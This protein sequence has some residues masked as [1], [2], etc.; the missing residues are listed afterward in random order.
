MRKTISS[1]LLAAFLLMLCGF[2]LQSEAGAAPDLWT[3]QVTLTQDT[4]DKQKSQT[5]DCSWYTRNDTL[6]SFNITSAEQLASVAK[7]VNN[8]YQK[9]SES[10]TGYD[11]VF[12]D[13]ADKVLLIPDDL[14]LSGHDW[15][16]IGTEAH[17]FRGNLLGVADGDTGT[18][19]TIS[20]LRVTSDSAAAGLYGLLGCVDS[21]K[22]QE[23]GISCLTVSGEITI[24]SGS[25]IA[26]AFA[27]KI[28]GVETPLSNLTADVTITADTTGDVVIGGIAGDVSN[29]SLLCCTNQGAVSVLNAAKADVGG[30][31]GIARNAVITVNASDG[32]TENRGVL[33]V[34]AGTANVGGIIGSL[35]GE[36]GNTLA[37]SSK[38]RSSGSGAEYQVDNNAAFLVS[39]GDLTVEA[40]VSANVGGIIGRSDIA[41]NL[42]HA[43]FIRN[44]TV[45]GSGNACVGGILGG[46]Y[47]D[48]TAVLDHGSFTTGIVLK[49]SKNREM[50]RETGIAAKISVT[51]D[52]TS[53][54][55]GICGYAERLTMAAPFAGCESG[56]KTGT[57]SI[58]VKSEAG[59][60]GG[61]AGCVKSGT[62]AVTAEEE[63]QV[64][65][66]AVSAENAAAVGAVLGDAV[67]TQ[68]FHAAGRSGDKAQDITVSA[69][70]CGNVG[71]FIG[72]LQTENQVFLTADHIS[73]STEDSSAAIGGAVGTVTKCGDITLTVSQVTV[74]AADAEHCAIGG[75][76]GVNHLSG[77]LTVTDGAADTQAQ[78]TLRFDGSESAVGGMIGENHQAYSDVSLRLADCK[79]NMTV[80]GSKCDVGGVIGESFAVLDGGWSRETPDQRISL[81]D[82]SVT[83]TLTESNIGGAAGLLHGSMKGV[84][85]QRL[86]IAQKGTGSQVGGLAGR[87][88]QSIC[89]AALFSAEI[90][91]DGADNTAGGA[92]GVYLADVT[93]ANVTILDSKIINRAAGSIIGGFA[94]ENRGLIRNLSSA[95]G[96]DIRLM[97]ADR[98]VAGGL[99]GSNSGEIDAAA[100]AARI[101]MPNANNSALSG[102]RIGG[103]VGE[104]TAAGS[105]R[106][107]LRDTAIALDGN[108]TAEQS[109]ALGGLIGRNAGLVENS[110]AACELSTGNLGNVYTG[111]LIGEMKGGSVRNCYTGDFRLTA[112]ADQA[113]L[114]GFLGWYQDGT[115]ENCYSAMEVVGAELDRGGAF[116]AC[117][118]S[119]DRELSEFSDC[120]FIQ[121]KNTVNSGLKAAATGSYLEF[122]EYPEALRAMVPE[123]L[124][125][126][127]EGTV[128]FRRYVDGKWDFENVWRFDSMVGEIGYA[129]PLLRM[130]LPAGSV[131]GRMDLSWYTDHVKQVQAQ[132]ED[133]FHL[134]SET[135]LT[136]F[137][138]LVNGYVMGLNAVDFAGQTVYLDCAVS[139]QASDWNAI[140]DRSDFAFAGSFDGQEKQISGL[141]DAADHAAGLFG[142]T[143]A[144]A[145]LRNVRLQAL[146]VESKYGAAAAA[147]AYHGGK[148]QNVTVTLENHA[149]IRGGTY[150]GG[151]AG[152]STGSIAQVSV[153][154]QNVVIT[155]A[156]AGGIAGESSKDI[157]DAAV[158]LTDGVIGSAAT[159]YAGG[160]AGKSGAALTGSLS[161]SATVQGKKAGGIV[162]EGV[163]LTATTAEVTGR[164]I[165][166]DYAGG[167]AGILSG[168]VEAEHLTV[169]AE[170]G[171]TGE[172]FSGGIAGKVSAAI[173]AEMIRV[174]AASVSGACSGGIAGQGM[175]LTVTT[176]EV[177]GK[178]IGTDY[179]GGIAGKIGS[180]TDTALICSGTISG[181]GRVGGMAGCVTGSLLRSSLDGRKSARVCGGAFVGGA[182]GEY[183]GTELDGSIRLSEISV[184]DVEIRTDN[185]DTAACAGGLFGALDKAFL[186]ESTLE[187]VTVE[188]KGNQADTMIGGIAGQVTDSIL[189]G[190]SAENGT[191][192]ARCTG[193]VYIGGA[194]GQLTVSSNADRTWKTEPT[195]ILGAYQGLDRV[196]LSAV[197]VSTDSGV[198]NE[199]K[200][201]YLTGKEAYAGGLVGCL[202]G[203][204]VYHCTVS[205][206]VLA[207]AGYQNLYVGGAAGRA[208]DA[209][210]V[211]NTV[212]C[213][214][215]A[216]NALR[217]Y[218]GGFV[219]ELASSTARYDRT[220]NELTLALHVGSSKAPILYAGGFA[221]NILGT[222]ENQLRDN[223]AV[224]KLSAENDHLNGIIYAGGFAGLAGYDQKAVSLIACTAEAELSVRSEDGGVPVGADTY[225]GGL[226][227]QL[228][229]GTIESS[230]ARSN[231]SANVCAR[232]RSGGFAGSISENAAAVN[233]FVVGD[234]VK[235]HGDSSFCG[236]FVGECRGKISAV[237]ADVADVQGDGDYVGPI[238]GL[239]HDISNMEYA[240]S[241]GLTDG[242]QPEGF[243]FT[244]ENSK[245]A[246]LEGVNGNRPM[247]T[248]FVSWDSQPELDYL[249][250][251]GANA[252]TVADASELGTVSALLN[253]SSIYALFSDGRRAA[254]AYLVRLTAD[255]KLT[256]E[257]VWKLWVPANAVLDGEQ[258]TINGIQV[259]LPD[260]AFCGFVME[261]AGD[262]RNLTIA[263]AE[264]T[265]GEYAGAA[266]G[267]NTGTLEQVIVRSSAISVADCV[268]VVVGVNEGTIHQAASFGE[269]VILPE[270]AAYT[271]GGIAG[272][273]SGTITECL[274]EADLKVVGCVMN[275]GGIAGESSGTIRNCMTA[276]GSLLTGICGSTANG[277]VGGI[278]GVLQ[279]SVENCI[280]LSQVILR[281]KD[282]SSEGG[283][284]YGRAVAGKVQGG[285]VSAIYDK[286]LSRAGDPKGTARTTEELLGVQV[287]AD[288]AF[289]AQEGLYPVLTW[290]KDTVIGRLS[291]AAFRFAEG[292]KGPE[293]IHTI[294]TAFPVVTADGVSVTEGEA[295]RVSQK[296]VTLLGKEG[297]I[298]LS[299]DGLSR[300]VKLS[301]E[302]V[303]EESGGG[304]YT[305]APAK[306]EEKGGI[307]ITVDG[308]TY[309]I[310]IAAEDAV[311][312]TVTVDAEKL[313]E[314]VEQA[315]EG[316]RIVIPLIG[317][318][319]TSKAVLTLQNVM[320]AAKKCME[321]QVLC[322]DTVLTIPADS[323]ELDSIAKTLGG[324][325]GEIPFTIAV[326]TLSEPEK[327]ELS[328]QTGYQLVGPVVSFRVTAGTGNMVCAVEHYGAW[329]QRVLWDADGAEVTTGVEIVGGKAIHKPTNGL[330]IFSL[331]DSVYAYIQNQV[332]FTDATGKW[333]EDAVNEMASRLIINGRGEGLFD[334]Q[335]T[336]TRA[337]FAAIVVRALG[338][339]EDGDGT[340]FADVSAADWYCGAVGTA[341]R[342]GLV[343]GRSADRFDPNANITRQEAM[344]LLQRAAELA[345]L[346]GIS[347]EI[348]GF[349]DA[350]QVSEWARSAAQFHVGTGLIQGDGNLLRPGDSI[351][352]AETAVMILRLLQK[353]GLIDVR[354]IA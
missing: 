306:E 258:H 238:A 308:K 350:D 75:A 298:R 219:G 295:V 32:V 278:A 89:N 227:G 226:I 19:P 307:A 206:G 14:D 63:A 82:I 304:G 266:A 247:L 253:D 114:G 141:W 270:S 193:N 96:M 327:A 301:D 348:D 268:G 280:S 58:Q 68:D 353:S 93:P 157:S 346:Q 310:G 94:G 126:S 179:A 166:T 177:M 134:T 36:G 326:K 320:D 15:V 3:D 248:A 88:E 236:G 283:G 71:G 24:S 254:E 223:S 150:A 339:H 91:L 325:T 234:T 220:E 165:G 292:D 290:L 337:E 155:A 83:S 60:V 138:A 335:G 284:L 1:I 164:I 2:S 34:K 309:D 169:Y 152:R 187:G 332:S 149:A 52:G 185:T 77:I 8:G 10:G 249:Y 318:K 240:Y 113:W 202:N 33:Q 92:A 97:K 123:Q 144:A 162:G 229:T 65:R 230:Y 293:T 264:I 30:L 119:T 305:P 107:S 262:L 57:V 102:F 323:M 211:D 246:Y 198:S 200:T 212:D 6:V 118:D 267:R 11:T 182:A 146:C 23:A 129:Y 300:L 201:R 256:D 17:P 250:R 239:M 159:D 233:C 115:V 44:I 225:V 275:L 66:L 78:L 122:E 257:K 345:G 161:A 336:A 46:Q 27:G 39:L 216:E 319:G 242:T 7:L 312:D 4:A 196:S 178:I 329:T 53:Y 31:C 244:T 59:A 121:K 13:F 299:L 64:Y 153:V 61:I 99:V 163:T 49:D 145:E 5:D 176:A 160:I 132:Q 69:V 45:T 29:P 221:G 117:Y 167:I 135:D 171:I 137:A 297:S 158:T 237:Y 207:A 56:N 12:P 103:L 104:N 279:G 215:T 241:E 55:G 40:S 170:N 235:A 274:N 197:T 43:A 136:G 22:N 289:T 342:M 349:D 203:G 261:N 106:Y 154:G 352:R 131:T 347:G 120:F 191:V 25:G 340:V 38:S 110:Y 333:Y 271:M 322:G 100:T 48:S 204:S 80:S 72:V 109:G 331:S 255:V 272:R 260:A 73:I 273:N 324:N 50:L 217:L 316:S 285:T 222:T 173:A 245:W 259:R 147:A 315:S 213:A 252:M 111:G 232:A 192:R 125:D 210:L 276:S 288:P 199:A 287:M 188:A 354:S 128:A 151:I 180:I 343:N 98:V 190:V 143:G 208:A 172:G 282:G 231:V 321:L 37:V 181:Q 195:A 302:S 62:V 303:E 224:T 174:E 108:G 41:V 116:F 328:R 35:P 228:Y 277:N 265:G 54:V 205:G 344:V 311:S 140:G 148:M 84:E 85:V 74:E 313:A 351:T 168:G 214:V 26:G 130:E 156:K 79:I 20:G 127:G 286:Q 90:S 330:T 101:T 139:L 21:V 67:L 47:G 81:N 70:N 263:G 18:Y 28:T 183:S 9:P 269:Y 175:T 16:P 87:S 317:E 95:D 124:A 76:A 184:K 194:A 142:Y 133:G 112:A 105:I 251:H 314:Y 341:F 338:L 42:D 296:Q 86:K 189:S 291:N 51:V 294:S 186:T 281:D 334:G 209:Y 243:D 218:A